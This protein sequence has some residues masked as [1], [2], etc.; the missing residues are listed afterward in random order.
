MNTSS[1]EDREARDRL[2]RVKSRNHPIGLASPSA[3]IKS[4]RATS[5]SYLETFG[6][7]QFIGGEIESVEFDSGCLCCTIPEASPLSIRATSTGVALDLEKRIGAGIH[8]PIL[9]LELGTSRWSWNRGAIANQLA[10]QC[11]KNG[12]FTGVEFYLYLENRTAISFCSFM[13]EAA[14]EPFLYWD[15]AT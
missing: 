13:N 8:Q 14:E 5:D 11:I 3:A 6:F 7:G 4:S 15:F 9:D 2:V 1:E 12:F 10:G